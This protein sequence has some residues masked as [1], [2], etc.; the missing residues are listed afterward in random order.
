MMVLAP[1]RTAVAY[2]RVVDPPAKT[3]EKSSKT[4]DSKNKSDEE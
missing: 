3:V 4:N 2:Q 1:A